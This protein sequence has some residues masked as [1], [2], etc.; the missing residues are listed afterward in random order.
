MRV[1]DIKRNKV[2][3]Q[4][5]RKFKESTQIEEGSPW[6]EVREYKRVGIEGSLHVERGGKIA[7]H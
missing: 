4:S 2:T 5:S 7:L 3:H 1:S 6:F